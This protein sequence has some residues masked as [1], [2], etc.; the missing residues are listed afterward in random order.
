MN[1]FLGAQMKLISG[2]PSARDFVLA[3]ERGETDGGA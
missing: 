1:R 3:S 2:Y